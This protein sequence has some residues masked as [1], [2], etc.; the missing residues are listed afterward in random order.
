MRSW[1]RTGAM[2][3][4]ACIVNL[5][6]RD[7]R[8]GKAWPRIEALIQAEG[9][10]YEVLFTEGPGHAAV[11]AA[12]LRERDD[13]D[14]VVA[15]GGDGTVHEVASGIRGSDRTLGIIP[16]GSG[17]DFARGHGIPLLDPEGSVPLLRSGVD[18][19]VG[20]MAIDGRPAPSLPHYPAPAPTEWDG[21]ASEAGLV[22]R[23]AF[24]ESDGG[25]TS[26][27]SR[28]KTEGVFKWIRGTNKY[29]ALG[30][31]AILGWKKQDAWLKID[32]EVIG[33]VDMSG[34]FTTISVETFGGGYRVAPGRVAT[35]DDF[36]LVIA[37]GLSKLQMLRLMGP[38]KKG[39]HV[40]MWGITQQPAKRFEI[41]NID[42]NG[43]PTDAPHDPPMYTQADGEPIFQTPT[44]VTWH[45]DQ[46]TVRG[47]ARIPNQLE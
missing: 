5:L 47:K 32:D 27:I 2:V 10:E 13:L 42:A 18:R 26:A 23:W 30:I 14:L 20:A 9:M 24:L 25:T 6:G 31:R 37:K 15:V 41:R 39:H 3:R 45:S 46:I 38:L 29:T 43:E 40:G 36:H 19:R 16:M 21:E 28:A 12:S 34:L 1:P 4:I 33:R 22:R 44:I 7:G 8:C 17:N 35:D 11:L